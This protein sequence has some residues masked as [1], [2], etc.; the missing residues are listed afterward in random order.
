M[1]FLLYCVIVI[2]RGGGVGMYGMGLRDLHSDG[3]DGYDTYDTIE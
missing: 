1:C 3:D 2:V